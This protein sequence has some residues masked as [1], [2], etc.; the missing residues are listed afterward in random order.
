MS[1]FQIGQYYTIDDVLLRCV[2][3]YSEKLIGFQCVDELD[4]NIIVRKN[5]LIKDYG[6][7]LI[8]DRLHLVSPTNKPVQQ[9]LFR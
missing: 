1:H 5:G 8:S 4:N 7:R 6:F 9:N 2:K 3:I